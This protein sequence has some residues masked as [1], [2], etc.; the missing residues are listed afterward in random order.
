M[1]PTP[2]PA[3]PARFLRPGPVLGWLSLAFGP[4]LQAGDA[5]RPSDFRPADFD[6]PVWAESGGMIVVEAEDLPYSDNWE[7]RHAAAP[8]GSQ[9][10]GRGYL[11][12]IG[13]GQGHRQETDP[14]HQYQGDSRDWLVIRTHLPKG[15]WYTF[16]LRITHAEYDGDNDIW[17]GQIGTSTPIQRAGSNDPGKFRWLGWGVQIFA[18]R[19]GPDALYCT[20]RSRQ[21][22]IDRIAI[23]R[24]DAKDLA[25]NPATPVSSLYRPSPFTGEAIAA[26]PNGWKWSAWGYLHDA[27]YPFVFHYD[28]DWLYLA[29][30][31][32]AGFFFYRYRD[33]RWGWTGLPHFPFHYDF[34]LADWVTPGTTQP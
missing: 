11:A 9:P 29:N 19:K 8:D 16:N 32:L 23:Y 13:P 10:T 28:H 30:D 21:F 34:T 33:S 12:W 2:T 15:G 18:L 26:L 14:Q 31:D 27:A 17:L 22:G 6:V 5:D 24:L 20:G 4:F 3:H 1:K 7:L 25:L